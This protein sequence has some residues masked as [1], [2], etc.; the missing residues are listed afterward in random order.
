[1]SIAALQPRHI[2]G[3]RGDVR[4]GIH[5]LDDATLLYPAGHNVVL[6]N[7]ETR[8]QQLIPGAVESEGILALAVSPNRKYLA[9]AERG[10]RGMVTVFDLR[11]LKRRKVLFNPVMAADGGCGLSVAGSG[12]FRLLRAADGGLKPAPSALAKREPQNY[13]A[14]AW[15]PD[16]ERERIVAGTERGDLLIVEA[17]DLRLALPFEGAPAIDA[18]GFAVAAADGALTLFEKEADEARMYHVARRMPMDGGGS[19]AV[20]QGLGLGFGSAPRVR[21]LALTAAED[22]LLLALASRQLLSLNLG[23][24]ELAKADEYVFEAVP[25]AFHAAEVTGVGTCLRKPLVATCS[26]DRTLRL[27]NTQDW[28]VEVSKAFI[29]E[30]LC[31][32]LHP[33]AHSVLVGFTDKLRL[34]TVLLDDF[35]L[36]KELGIKA[37]TECCFSTGGHLFAAANSTAISIF[38][39][40]TCEVIGNLR[41]HNGKVRSIMWS[42]DDTRLVSAGVDGAVYEWALAGFRRE[43]E[44]VIK[45]C[46]YSTVIET[47]ER[48]VFA[49]GSDRKIKE[50]ADTSGAGMQVVREVEAGCVVTQLAMAAGGR[51]LFTGTDS[52]ALRSYKLP[53][54]PDFQE[55]RFCSGA[56]SRLRMGPDDA[57]LY[58]TSADGSLFV[59]DVRDRDPARGA[60][61]RETGEKLPYAEEVLVSK[62]DLEEKK[63]RIAELDAQVKE[64]AMENEYALRLKDAATA[65][66]LRELADRGAAEREAER[67]RAD[68]LLAEK[69]EAELEYEDQLRQAEQRHQAA[70][71]TLEAQ[72]QAAMAA[73]TERLESVLRDKAALNARWDEQNRALVEGHERVVHE[74]TLEFEGKLAEEVDARM[75]SMEERDAGER[76]ASEIKRQLEEDADREIEELQD[77]YEGRLA[78]EREAGLR[79]K[80]ENGIMKKKFST[81]QKEI[82]DQSAE[83]T[84][85]F[86]HKKE[87]Y[88]AMTGLERDVAALKREV[89]E[90]DDT[91][92]DKEK[93]IHDLKRKN[94]EL[95][96]F[97]F[98]L[99]YKIKELKR[100]IEPR[101]AELAR[102][103]EQIQART[104]SAPDS[105]HR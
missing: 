57:Q 6:L 45:G 65:E 38:N 76:E 93:R 41:G 50:L 7:T 62:A 28:S 60:G 77:K 94:Q 92:G 19:D 69:N 97:K 81:L 31:V 2:F 13:T 14:H 46:Q 70:M 100:Q 80:G 79:L 103:K 90:R 29:E 5:A 68:A 16:S 39:A 73:E 66:R 96:K 102:L 98:V 30:A 17:G 44:T 27:W 33:S 10:E 99:D 11:T 8:G 72:H 88:A 15:L 51:C 1:M 22:A 48:V 53:L 91:I 18:I 54:G 67:A 37:C 82:D 61:K 95:E 12:V 40:Y 20:G 78:A 89:A 64:V 34:F 26:L 75:R 58:A 74:V 47:P 49:A 86:E 25:H 21:S 36:V 84:Q 3:C 63:Q 85:L 55:A 4:D 56:I 35:K 105:Q 83:V 52:G 43:R 24:A 32:A 9:V 101:E 104:W 71:T 59:F 23:A 87:L 42:H